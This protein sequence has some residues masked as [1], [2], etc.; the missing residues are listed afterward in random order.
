MQI[1]FVRAI[2]IGGMLFAAA[3]SG[4][5]PE[6]AATR[7]PATPGTP[8]L[9]A[10][11]TIQATLDAAGTAQPIAEATLSTKLMGTVTGVLVHEGDRVAAGQ[12]LVHIDARELAAR[13]SQ[14]QASIAGARAMQ[15]DAET[16]AGR[17]RA[18]YADS[19]ATRAQLD[20]VET[21]LA[22]A[23]AGVQ[24]ATAGAGELAATRAYAD[25]RAPFAGIVT[26][27][28]VDP[29]AFAAPGT[30]LVTVQNDSRLRVVV[31][32]AP[33]DVR[34]LARGTHVMA[35]IEDTAVQ[36][37]V[38]GVV[39]S[40]GNVYTVNAIVENPR[41][42][43]MA[44]G[45][46]SIAIPRGRRQA[47]LVPRAAIKREGDLTGVIVRDAAGDDVRWVRLGAIRGSFV[48]VTSGL[49]AGATIV[50]PPTATGAPAPAGEP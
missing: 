12:P 5:G 30:P 29:G 42:T 48:E 19:A 41:G 32:A 15:R 10:D 20:A 33:E 27:R 47:V 14:V 39:P 8:Y 6:R 45:A 13:D 50:V 2:T 1:P 22:R 4:S 7:T 44:N 9:V 38:E 16:Q 23:N 28:F 49:A 18:L 43:L 40:G 31:N 37:T 34:G 46:A 25:V 24:A 21:A 11:S 36:A 3:C 35:T 26:H 17:I